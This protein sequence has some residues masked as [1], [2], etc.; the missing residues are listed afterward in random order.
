MYDANAISA[1]VYNS[2]SI[3][4][5]DQVKSRFLELF[6]NRVDSSSSV[7]TLKEESMTD[8]ICDLGKQL[9]THLQSDRRLSRVADLLSTAL[10]KSRKFTSAPQRRSQLLNA[11]YLSYGYRS[12]PRRESKYLKPK[13]GN[14]AVLY[15]GLKVLTS[16]WKKSVV[17]FLSSSHTCLSYGKLMRLATKTVEHTRSHLL[18]SYTLPLNCCPS[19]WACISFDNYDVNLRSGM[20]HYVAIAAYQTMGVEELDGIPRIGSDFFRSLL[21]EGGYTLDTGAD[22][23]STS[24]TRVE[25]SS[26]QLSTYGTD[27]SDLAVEERADE[28]AAVEDIFVGDLLSAEMSFTEAAIKQSGKL[29]LDLKRIKVPR[30]TR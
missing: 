24:A 23:Q 19:R 25:D 17:D 18:G 30:F 7:W 8:P 4:T 5:V 20:T 11:G 2:L 10:T 14:L 1:E 16:T 26:L 21:V 27:A 29:N 6:N 12:K 28:N 9:H 22:S 3:F 15:T 13:G